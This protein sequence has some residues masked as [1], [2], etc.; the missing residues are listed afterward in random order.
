MPAPGCSAALPGG[1][2]WGSRIAG[3]EERK[4]PTT[5]GYLLGCLC[6]LPEM[7]HMAQVVRQLRQLA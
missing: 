7:A 3:F 2:R 4:T 5:A 1:V 6:Q